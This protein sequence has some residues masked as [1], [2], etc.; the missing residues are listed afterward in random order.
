MAR[1]KPDVNDQLTVAATIFLDRLTGKL[2]PERS[3]PSWRKKSIKEVN[4]EAER[5]VKTFRAIAREFVRQLPGRAQKGAVDS[6]L[7]SVV[8]IIRKKLRT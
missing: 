4:T 6:A 5:L 7:R 2:K 1:L 3:T 8:P